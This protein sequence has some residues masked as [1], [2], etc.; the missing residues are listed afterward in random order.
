MSADTPDN[1][2]D[3]GRAIIPYRF[4]MAEAIGA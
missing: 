4:L 1:K 3:N 2:T